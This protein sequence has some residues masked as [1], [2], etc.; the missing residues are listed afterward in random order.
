MMR[1]VGVRLNE[2]F[3]FKETRTFTG[4]RRVVFFFLLQS[5]GTILF[6]FTFWF[7]LVTPDFQPAQ[8]SK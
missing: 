3:R 5:V 2:I 8:S 4:N 6:C 7:F 1:V